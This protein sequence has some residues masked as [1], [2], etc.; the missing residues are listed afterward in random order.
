MKRRRPIKVVTT[1]W[2]RSDKIVNTE[3]GKSD[4]T[5]KLFAPGLSLFEIPD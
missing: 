4:K 2:G 1:E 5:S 3:R